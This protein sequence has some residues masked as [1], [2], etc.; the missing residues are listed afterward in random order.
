MKWRITSPNR[1]TGLEEE[2]FLEAP[3]EEEARRKASNFGLAISWLAPSYAGLQ[4][5]A[6]LLML[7]AVLDFIAAAVATFFALAA[8]ADQG[9]ALALPPTWTAISLVVTGVF[10]VGLSQLCI[11]V[12]AIAQNSHGIY[13]LLKLDRDM[14]LAKPQSPAEPPKPS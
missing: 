11:A 5:L 10:L 7:L 8:L 4:R 1:K 3:S 14:R 2:I 13:Q 12:R 9:P 6:S